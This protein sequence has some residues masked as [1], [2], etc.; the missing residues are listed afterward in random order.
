MATSVQSVGLAALGGLLWSGYTDS[1][2]ASPLVLRPPGA[3]K[4]EDFLSSVYQMW[5]MCRGMC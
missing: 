3:L 5:S 2:K 1:V 4:E